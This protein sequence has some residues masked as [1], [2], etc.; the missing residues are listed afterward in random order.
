M[1]QF[2]TRCIATHYQRLLVDK[3]GTSRKYNVR[4]VGGLG[5]WG[6][7]GGM[8][9]MGMWMGVRMGMK[10]KM[11]DEDGDGDGVEWQ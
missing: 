8:T 7:E 1:V 5:G 2:Q 11:G 9:G 10:I 4:M 3:N 6:G